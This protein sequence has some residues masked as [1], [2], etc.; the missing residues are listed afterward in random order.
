[1][2]LVDAGS[3]TALNP[4]IA[5]ACAAGIKVISFDQIVT[6]KCAWKVGQ[7]HSPGQRA[8]GQWMAKT[9]K[10]TGGIFVDRGLPGAPISAIIHDSFLE[11]LKKYGPN[12][13]VLAEYDGKYSIG[14]EQQAV[15]ALLAGHSDVAGVMTQG[16]CTPI[17]NAFKQAGLKN[18]PCTAYGYNGE[19][20]ACARLNTP[21]AIL[22][23]SPIVIQIA[24]KLGLNAMD[25]KAVPARSTQVPVPWSPVRLGSTRDDRKPGRCRPTN[26]DQQE[27]V[28]RAGSGARAPLHASPVQDHCAA[29]G[30]QAL[31]T[32]TAL[33]AGGQTQASA[34]TGSPDLVLADIFKAFGGVRAVDGANL[35]CYPGEVHGLIG[36]NGAGK[37]TLIK[38]LSGVF[39]ADAGEI[40]L[41]GERLQPRAR[42]RGRRLRNRHGLSGAEPDSPTCPSPRTS[43]TGSSRVSGRRRISMRALRSAARQALADYGFPNIRPGEVVSQLRLADRQIL[44]I[45][46]ALIRKPACSSSTSRPRA[47]LPEQVRVAVRHGARRSPTTV[48]SPSSSRTGSRR[49]RACATG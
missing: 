23:G 30:G 2:I 6:A 22:S 39:P 36:E 3:P 8:I 41:R 19:L 26:P 18:V 17:F 45:I 16:Y 47:L 15:S 46:K 10:N 31:K 20:V 42:R 14:P 1:M 48:A 44:E 25:R 28:P 4:T 40:T 38:I 21:C 33:T 43:S 7:D 37:S 29:G 34:R 11:G 35:E 49:S 32:R 9:L 24:M 27:R 12:V 13:K 5:R